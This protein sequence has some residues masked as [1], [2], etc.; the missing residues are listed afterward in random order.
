MN[1]HKTAIRR[2]K[3]SNPT[4]FLVDTKRIN[5]ESEECLD[6]GCGRGFDCDHLNIDGYDPYWRPQKPTKKYDK[7]IC[8]YVLN[9]IEDHNTR[10]DVITNIQSLLSDNG[11][12]FLSVRNDRANLKGTTKNGTWQGVVNLTFPVVTKNS[13]FIMYLIRKEQ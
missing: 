11:V 4:K 9:V 10:N 7:I 5:P 12:C 3:L 6:Y 13:G 8:N 1:E 2:N